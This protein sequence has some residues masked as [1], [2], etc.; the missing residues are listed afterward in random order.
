M[1]LFHNFRLCCNSKKTF[2]LIVELY[3]WKMLT[4]CFL[5][6]TASMHAPGNTATYKNLFFLIHVIYQVLKFSVICAWITRKVGEW[7][8][9]V[10]MQHKKIVC[11]Y[12]SAHITA[13]NI[14]LWLLLAGKFMGSNTICAVPPQSWLCFEIILFCLLSLDPCTYS[15][16]PYILIST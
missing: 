2:A 6:F 10:F 11:V 14:S 1:L 13:I 12:C 16:P 7:T 9:L 15:L 8:V 4:V 3:C 5:R